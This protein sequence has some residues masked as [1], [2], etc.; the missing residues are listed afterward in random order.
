MA[1]GINAG[2]D[3]HVRTK[4]ENRKY[5][6]S[7]AVNPIVFNTPEK[8]MHVQAW[9]YLE[10]GETDHGEAISIH[11]VRSSPFSQLGEMLTSVLE[12]TAKI[13]LWQCFNYALLL[14][15]KL[16]VGMI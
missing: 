15:Q 12:A 14:V 7:L 16:V 4:G 9:G 10:A 1:G 2:A 5:S 3:Y 6:T 8:A 11:Y 13:Y